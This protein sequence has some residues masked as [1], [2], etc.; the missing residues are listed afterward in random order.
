VFAGNFQVADWVSSGNGRMVPGVE[1]GK[2]LKSDIA[3]GAGLSKNY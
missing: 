1:Q 2:K 3:S